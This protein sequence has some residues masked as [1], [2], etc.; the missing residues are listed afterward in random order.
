M[1]D[2][3]LKRGYLM[4]RKTVI[5]IVALVAVVVVMVAGTSAFAATDVTNTT[6]NVP[7]FGT[8]SV[9]FKT[10]PNVYLY[11]HS[12]GPGS[13]ATSYVA[14]TYHNQGDKAYGVDPDYTGMYV[15]TIPAGST[16]LTG[17]PTTS[18]AGSTGDFAAGT[19][20]AK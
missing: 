17:F 2:H 14:G 3:L 4:I 12:N 10:S 15:Q 19:W 5:S 1:V 6:G 9:T 20:T 8:P 16:T 7:A 11:Y 13:T 18:A